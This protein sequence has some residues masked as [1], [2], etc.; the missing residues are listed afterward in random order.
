MSTTSSMSTTFRKVFFDYIT[1][2][3]LVWIQQNLLGKDKIQEYR[4]GHL[5]FSIYI[6]NNAN[7]A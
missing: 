1:L 4:Q 6:S 2:I 3:D 5:S 7:K